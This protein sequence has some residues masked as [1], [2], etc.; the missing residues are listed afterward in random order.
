MTMRRRH[1]PEAV[2]EKLAAI[3]DLPRAELIELWTAAY[4]RPP[5]KGLS[6]RLLEY[7]AAYYVQTQAYGGPSPA[8]RRTLR[9]LVASNRRDKS[10]STPR[11]VVSKTLP[12]GTRL[13]REWHGRPYTVEVLETGF[14]CDGQ[15]YQSLS[16]VARAITGARWSGP[17][18]FWL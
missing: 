8:L 6:R 12:P 18:F 4:N 9:R 15:R 11:N 14:L 17:R 2:A 3:S 13:L 5:P 10:A 1:S 16:E 7:A